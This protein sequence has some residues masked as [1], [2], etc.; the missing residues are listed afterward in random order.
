MKFGIY[1]STVGKFSDPLLLA[2]LAQEAEE[3]GWQGVFIYDHIGQPSAV[4]DAWVTL[5]AV[6]VKT[7]RIKLGT[8]VTPVPRRRPWKLARETV[9]LDHLSHGRLILGVGLGWSAHEFEAFGEDGDPKVRAEKLDEGLDVLAGLW[10]GETFSFNGNHYQVKEACFLPPPVQSPRIPVWVCGAWSEK[11]AP[12]RRAARWD[13]VIAILPPGMNRAILPDEVKAVRC[14]IKQHR[15]TSDPFDTVV[16]LWSEG[17]HT[18]DE[19]LSVDQY[20]EAG[21]TWWLEDV[22]TERFSSLND[23]RTR[24]HQGPPG[25]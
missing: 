17:E 4:A 8:I 3:A 24:L 21:V 7:T 1:L 13:G 5:A 14:Y 22:S 25:K 6:A 20:T 23:V 9:T 11:K 12:F 10:S 18:P 2:E 15:A 19:Q 16:I